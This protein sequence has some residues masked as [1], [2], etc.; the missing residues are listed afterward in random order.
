MYQI[1]TLLN[2]K[3][4]SLLKWNLSFLRSELLNHGCESSILTGRGFFCCCCLFLVLCFNNYFSPLFTFKQ[5]P[6]KNCNIHTSNIIWTSY[7]YKYTHT[8]IY[9]HIHTHTQI[10][11]MTCFKRKTATGCYFRDT[12]IGFL[13]WAC[14]SCFYQMVTRNQSWSLTIAL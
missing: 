5:S 13:E 10:Q 3:I 12:D 9:M 6:L 8:E 1:F 7:V 14:F 11:C 4:L 2:T